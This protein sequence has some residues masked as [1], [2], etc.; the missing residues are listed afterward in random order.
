M[1]CVN[2]VFFTRVELLLL[3]S[4]ALKT[5]VSKTRLSIHFITS[6]DMEWMAAIPLGCNHLGHWL[7]GVP[8][9][10]SVMSVLCLR[11]LSC[12]LT[13]PWLG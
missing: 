6:G 4:Y 8:Y 7:M 2:E 12:G 5:A 3:L 13:N 11:F 9:V 10:L 1:L